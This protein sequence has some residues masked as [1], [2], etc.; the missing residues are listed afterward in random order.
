[1]F[2]FAPTG[3]KYGLMAVLAGATAHAFGILSLDALG[4]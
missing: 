2:T 3:K 1:M 4:M